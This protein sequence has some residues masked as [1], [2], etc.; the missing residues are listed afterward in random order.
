MEKDELFLEIRTREHQHRY[1]DHYAQRQLPVEQ[2]HHH[3]RQQ[4]IRDVPHALHQT[5]GQRACDAV[6]VGHDACV[7]IA[8]A[9]LVEIGE[10]QRLQMVERLAFQIAADIELGL[11]RAVGGNVVRCGLDDHD[12]NVQRQPAADALHGLVRNEVVDGVLL[13]QR[14]N[15]VHA[16]ADRTGHDHP[17]KQH[18]I[19]L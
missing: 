13:E 10:G 5:P 14:D 15:C 4:Q 19:G 8:D 3:D 2:E 6:R 17:E 9:V 1:D 18:F 11:A 16:A 7:G 12:Q